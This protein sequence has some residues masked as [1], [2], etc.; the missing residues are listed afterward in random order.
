MRQPYHKGK[1]K[2]I[3]LTSYVKAEKESDLKQC[4]I[5]QKFPI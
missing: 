4:E 5:K 3:K 1:L 2:T